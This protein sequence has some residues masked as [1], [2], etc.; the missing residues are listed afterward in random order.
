[1]RAKLYKFLALF[2]YQPKLSAE[3]GFFLPSQKTLFKRAFRKYLIWMLFT[4]VTAG[5]L[6]FL[7]FI[8]GICFF[9]YNGNYGWSGAYPHAFV[10]STGIYWLMILAPIFII[11]FAHMYMFRRIHAD[12]SRFG[13]WHFV[14]FLSGS[15]LAMMPGLYIASAAYVYC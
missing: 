3:T 1:M 5:A 4:G 2:G 10:V 12:D 15:L 6:E 11:I 7:M 13:L 8:V 14:L 9:Y